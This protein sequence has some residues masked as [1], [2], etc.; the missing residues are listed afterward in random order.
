[1]QLVVL[2]AGH[3]TRFGGLKQI[4]PVG[5]N[6]E[7]II[8]YTAKDAVAAGFD[9][10]VL[11]VREEVED[12]LLDHIGEHWPPELEV[13]PVVQGPVLGTAQAVASAREAVRGAFGVVNAD[14]LYGQQAI[15]LLADEVRVLEGTT[16]SLVGYRL[17]DTI[18]RDDTVTRGICETDGNR[19]V[20]VVEQ[21]VTRQGES[22]AAHPV[23][24][25]AGRP[26]ERLSGDET[27]SM[28]LWGLSE[29]IFDHLQGAIDA[30]DP[31]TAPHKPGKPAELLL[32]YVVGELVTAGLIE[33][34][35]PRTEGRCIGITHPDDLE[36]VRQIV[37]CERHGLA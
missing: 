18:L 7:A 37:G 2:A 5:P 32:P 16:C 27:V 29:S 21:E 9:G 13:V 31:A 26:E 24:A 11:I 3:G 6:G 20:R 25:P 15:A 30:F 28:N 12:E 34:R 35:V 23:G 36:I 19:L 22:Y 10:V 33:V 14:D 4:A 1:V 17:A 8:D